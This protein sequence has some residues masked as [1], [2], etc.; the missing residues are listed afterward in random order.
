MGA[1]WPLSLRVAQQ[2][3]QIYKAS[4]ELGT[5]P[6]DID[7]LSIETPRLANMWEPLWFSP[8]L[9]GIVEAKF[10]DEAAG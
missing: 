3:D 6:S 4:Q 8:L 7:F 2:V 9:K 1:F 10:A 5:E